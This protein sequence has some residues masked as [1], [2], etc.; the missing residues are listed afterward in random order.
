M[1]L[2]G[3]QT[4]P[5]SRDLLSD[6]AEC[7]QPTTTHLQWSRVYHIRIVVKYSDPYPALRSDLN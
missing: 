4:K 3:K 1:R 2:G 5:L 6:W 7:A